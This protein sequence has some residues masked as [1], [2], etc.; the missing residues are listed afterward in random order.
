MWNIYVFTWHT[1]SIQ[2][3]LWL[4][5]FKKVWFLCVRPY[6]NRKIHL[7]PCMCWTKS[8][9][10]PPAHPTAEEETPNNLLLLFSWTYQRGGHPKRFAG[11][12]MISKKGVDYPVIRLLFGMRL[13]PQQQ[14]WFCEKCRGRNMGTVVV[15]RIVPD[16]MPAKFHST[17]QQKYIVFSTSMQCMAMI[18]HNLA[19]FTCAHNH[20]PSSFCRWE[21]SCWSLGAY[22]GCWKDD[23]GL[24]AWMN[25]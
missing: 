19:L 12:K 22:L 7:K 13:A 18:L 14:T 3:A 4:P 6:Q 17:L 1:K 5:R 24:V 2:G 8:R 20:G 16:A 10:P 25:A 23:I 11:V 9:M 15:F 21:L